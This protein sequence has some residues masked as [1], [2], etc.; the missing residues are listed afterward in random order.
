MQQKRYLVKNKKHLKHNYLTDVLAGAL[1]GILVA[2]ILTK[3]LAKQKNLNK[4]YYI[5]FAVV[6]LSF[7]GIV[8]YN[9]ASNVTSGVIDASQ[10]YFDS[11][12]VAKMLGILTGFVI[13]IFFEKKYVPTI[14]PINAP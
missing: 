11:E 1:I 12:D 7:I 9:Y 13:A 6:V 5:L 2:Y 4:V 14:I 10:F 8:I 3:L